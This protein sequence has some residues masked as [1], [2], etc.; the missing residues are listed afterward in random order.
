MKL[1]LKR[2]FPF[3]VNRYLV[4]SRYVLL[5][6]T[7]VI[8]A[9]IYPSNNFKYDFELGRPWRYDNLYAP[10]TFAIQKDK[11]IVE[12]ERENARKNFIPYYKIKTQVGDEVEKKFAV[13]LATHFVE[14]RLDSTVT[15]HKSDSAN[16]YKTGIDLIEKIYRKGIINLAE[17]HK[18]KF[19]QVYVIE[20]NVSSLHPIGSFYNLQQAFQIIENEINDSPNIVKGFLTPLIQSTLSPNISYDVTISDKFLAQS[21]ADISTTKGVVQKGEEIVAQGTLIDEATFQKLLS[22]RSSY[23]EKN[24]SRQHPWWMFIGYLIVST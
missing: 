1:N 5:V 15:V 19:N 12:E 2:F 6:L 8:I 4:I 11:K 23:E 3:I 17:N 24:L 13:E 18:Q 7:T 9:L 20:K 16:Y 14:L 10:Y 22:L 21:I